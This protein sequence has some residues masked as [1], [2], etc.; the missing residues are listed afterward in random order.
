MLLVLAASTAQ[1]GAQEAGST[2]ARAPETGS[3]PAPGDSPAAEPPGMVTDRPDIT[4]STSIV[5]RGWVQLET[6]E[7]LARESDASTLLAGPSTLARIGVASRLE[8]RLA[9][10][11]ILHQDAEGDA[12]DPCAECDV[13]AAG[14]GAVGIKLLL[15][16]RAGAIP[17]VALLP[18]LTLPVG[19]EPFSTGRV[20]PALKLAL[21]GDVTDGLGWG[22]NLGAAWLS[23]EEGEEGEEEDGRRRFLSW[24]LSFGMDLG[25]P[26][27]AFFEYFGEDPNGEPAAHVLDAGLT[28]GLSPDAQLDASGGVGLDSGAPDWFIGAGVSV[29]FDL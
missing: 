8:L 27:G 26:A 2:P 10:L 7:V 12:E 29:R 3:T 14:D 28:W 19:E 24:S 9:W 15:A 23:G 18:A 6:G 21:A 25:G 4:E 17:D 16:E 5:P 1:A 22:A 13:T 20:D 11:G